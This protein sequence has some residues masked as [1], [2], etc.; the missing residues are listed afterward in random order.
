MFKSVKSALAILLIILTCS[1]TACVSP[2]GGLKSYVSPEKGYE[3]LYPNG[4]IPMEL[5]KNNQKVDL[6]FRDLIKRT[7]NL[8]VIVSNIPESQTLQ[9]LGTP[10]EVGY[11]FFQE[12]NNN[13]NVDREVELIRA[14]S[15]EAKGNT[16]YILEYEVELSDQEKRHDLASVSISRGKLFTFNLSVPQNRWDKVKDSFNLIVNSFSVR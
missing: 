4:W 12:L 7:E 16:Y 8:S 5:D 14:E 6:V 15:R 2:L 10:S 3:F 13:P 11:R 9:G 1:L